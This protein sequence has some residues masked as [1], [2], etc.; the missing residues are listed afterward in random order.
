MSNQPAPDAKAIN[1]GMLTLALDWSEETM[2]LDRLSTDFRSLRTLQE[3]SVYP[4]SPLIM[5][6]EQYSR[7]FEGTCGGEPSEPT[8]FLIDCRYNHHEVSFCLHLS[9]EYASVINVPQEQLRAALRGALTPRE[10]DIAVL[11]F[12][13]DTIRSIAGSLHI[14]EGT[15]KRTIYNVYQ[16]MRI[17]SQVELIR[18]I[19]TLLAQ[20][21][22]GRAD[23]EE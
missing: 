17:S 4:L 2:T 8:R 6:L 19:Y 5:L 16:K 20:Q 10:T 3:K 11:L 13:G 23:A 9:N 7:S 15:V 22:V 18:E 14:S 12:Q 21:A 1:S